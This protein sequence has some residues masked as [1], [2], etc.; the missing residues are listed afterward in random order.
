MM[1][2]ATVTSG[3][4]PAPVAVAAAGRRDLPRPLKG[5]RLARSV[6]LAPFLLAA[7]LSGCAIRPP[8]PV[9]LPYA[10]AP[11]ATS[12]RIPISIWTSW[13]RL[14]AAV[15]AEVPKCTASPDACVDS[16]AEGTLL[17]Y[18]EEDWEPVGRSVLGQQLGVKGS[19]WRS[20]PIGVSITGSHFEVTLHL[21][22]RA[23]FGFVGG[24]E[25]ASCGVND[26]AREATVK[27][28]GDFR[29]APGWYVDPTIN[30]E[31]IPKNLCR[32]TMLNFDLSATLAETM[33]EQLQDEADDIEERIRQLTNVRSQVAP[34]WAWLNQPVALGRGLWFEIDPSGAS[35][36][37]P[38]ISADE[39]YLTLPVALKARPRVIL[40]ARPP[41]RDN[42]LPPLASG[43]ISPD[44][45][46]DISGTVEWAEASA[47]LT[48]ILGGDQGFSAGARGFQKFRVVKATAS[49]S[50][51]QVV[52]ALQVHGVLNGTFI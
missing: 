39:R 16:D 4:C 23:R 33:R 8:V 40:G 51:N 31:V 5:G 21:L 11:S 44:F 7:V 34:I 2:S 25:L 41:V 32:A 14:L 20:D 42:P 29:L 18:S 19:I 43:D 17:I 38:V 46:I 52:I 49:G 10:A 30:V 27:L 50:G 3:C 13:P 37:L 24:R 47:L 48:D 35:A 22:Y 12:E 26:A 36:G 1:A 9:S 28:S 6:W 45:D 15:E